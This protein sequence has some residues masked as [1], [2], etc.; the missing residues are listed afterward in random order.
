MDF[1]AISRYLSQGLVITP[2]S[3]LWGVITYPCLRYLVLATKSSYKTYTASQIFPFSCR[4][5]LIDL[6]NVHISKQ[7]CKCFSCDKPAVCG[8][9]VCS[10]D[11]Q[12]MSFPLMHFTQG[13][14][15]GGQSTATQYLVNI[16]YAFSNTVLTLYPM[17]FLV[18]MFLH[19]GI[20]VNN[21]SKWQ[22]TVFGVKFA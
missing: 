13:T 7:Q 6:Q 9:C 21:A 17:T 3:K 8:V 19:H 16:S 15:Y 4:L 14:A 10:D 5:S 18:M 12:Y 11:I 1:A 2:H 22:S 20:D